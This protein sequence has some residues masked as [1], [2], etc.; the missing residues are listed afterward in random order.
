M[1]AQIVTHIYELHQLESMDSRRMS[2]GYCSRFSHWCFGSIW[3]QALMSQRMCM[4]QL[5]WVFF[6]LKKN[7]LSYELTS[8]AHE[9]AGWHNLWYNSLMPFFLLFE[10]LSCSCCSLATEWMKGECTEIVKTEQHS[11]TFRWMA[12]AVYVQPLPLAYNYD[13]SH[14]KC[15]RT[16]ID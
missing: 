1:H 8:T 11:I 15:D 4:C 12:L 5:N 9:I 6:F 13:E 7:A 3:M 2:Y 16:Y 14:V 10:M